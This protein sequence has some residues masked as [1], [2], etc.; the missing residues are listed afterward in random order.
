MVKNGIFIEGTE[1]RAFVNGEEILPD[2]DGWFHIAYSYDP[3][4]KHDGIRPYFCGLCSEMI[5]EESKVI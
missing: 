1:V 4:H 2:E 3:D 5:I